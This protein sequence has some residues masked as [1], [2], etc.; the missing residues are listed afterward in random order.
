MLCQNNTAQC[1]HVVLFL[2]TKNAQYPLALL[3]LRTTDASANTLS[4]LVSLPLPFKSVSYFKTLWVMSV[5][6]NNF[7][8]FV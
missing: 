1:T 7:D 4:N 6:L 5:S 3:L 8:R 2:T